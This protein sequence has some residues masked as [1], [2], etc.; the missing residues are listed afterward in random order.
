MWNEGSFASDAVQNFAEDSDT[1]GFDTEAQAYGGIRDIFTAAPII[2]GL[3]KTATNFITDGAHTKVG[4]LKE[5]LLDLYKT[6]KGIE[7]QE[8]S[9]YRFKYVL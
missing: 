9:C 8:Y 3:G 5:T 7:E 1:R 4:S 2:G 6:T